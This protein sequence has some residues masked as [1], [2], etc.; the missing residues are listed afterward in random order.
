VNDQIAR[1]R[2]ILAGIDDIHTIFTGDAVKGSRCFPV[3]CPDRIKHAAMEIFLVILCVLMIITI[4]LVIYFRPIARHSKDL[5]D[6]IERLQSGLKEDFRISRDESNRAARD[7]RSELGDIFNHFRSETGESIRSMAEQHTKTLELV[8][9]TIESKLTRLATSMEESSRLI[10]DTLSN[11]L[12]DFALEQR[13]KLDDIRQEQKEM[14]HQTM[15]QLERINARVEEKLKDLS[16]Q[17]KADNH[18]V[19]EV[20]QASFK[21]F[22]ETF[23]RNVESFNNLQREKFRQLDER[24][25][26]LL[27]S[28]EKK[29]EEMRATVDEKLQKTL[30]ERIGQSF[31]LVNKQ[32]ES[33]QKGLGEMQTLAQDVGG[34]KRVLSNVKMRGGFGEIQLSML[35]EQILA[36]EQYE[37]NV[38]VKPDM[39]ESVEFAVKLPGRDENGSAVWLPIDAKFPKEVYEQL[40]AAYDTGDA[41]NV[42]AAQK[43]L[44]AAIRKMG[45]DICTKYIDP[46]TTTDF[47]IMFLPFEGIY[48]EVVRKA[49]L[50]ETLQR[51]CKVVVTG[52][53]TLAAILNSLQMGFRTLAIQQ[54]SSEVW[55]VLGAV[56]KEFQHFGGMLEKAQKNIQTASNQIDEVM[57]KRTRAI[58]RT[59]KGVEA[60]GEAEAKALL[61]EISNHEIIDDEES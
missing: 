44:E 7:N 15:E 26:R 40:Q 29:L 52:P 32:L 22:Q 24:Q 20:L 21:G 18:Q 8:N 11:A 1:S 60:L 16:G 4:V 19:R 56:K 12:K 39:L 37:R 49:S 48:A 14:V 17:A 5:T 54:R 38:K 27:E 47:A 51:E 2:I 9:A 33:V 46:P 10:R 58:Q 57:G 41:S 59:L 43:T 34:L 3:N 61:P 23:D 55:K 31:E 50:L 6:K 28:T 45:R 13:L 53:T 30:N 25:S 36:P 35:L 42:D